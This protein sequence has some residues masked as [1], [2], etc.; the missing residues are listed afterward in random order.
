MNSSMPW[1]CPQCGVDNI[2]DSQNSHPIEAGGCGYVRFPAGV[3]I[4]SDATGKEMTIRVSSSFGT[5]SLN[6]LGDPDIKFVSTG[7]FVVEKSTS[8]GGWLIT[9]SPKALNPLFLNGLPIG[10]EGAILKEGDKLSIKDKC[11]RLTVHLLL[12]L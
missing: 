7:Q 10:L 3:V 9:S 1:K 6:L 11:F 4:K 2:A 8:K 12:S 5:S